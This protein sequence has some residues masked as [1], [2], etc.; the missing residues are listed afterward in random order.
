MLKNILELMP[1]RIV[2]VLCNPATFARD[3]KNLNEMYDI[4]SVSMI[5]LF[6]QIFHLESLAFLRLPVKRQNH[7]NGIHRLLYKEA[8]KTIRR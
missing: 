5:D 8:Q 3:L 6:P 4:E 7:F 1:E 2:Y